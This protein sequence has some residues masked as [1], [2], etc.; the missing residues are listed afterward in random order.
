[1]LTLDYTIKRG[2]E[3]FK[4]YDRW[5]TI[6]SNIFMLTAPNGHGKS[7]FLNVI[8]L[9]LH[10]DKKLEN[11]RISESIKSKLVNTANRKDQELSFDINIV[12]SKGISLSLQKPKNKAIKVIEN[13]GAQEKTLTSDLF[14]KKYFLIYDIPENPLGKLSMLVS[15]VDSE[16]KRYN[17]K[18]SDLRIHLNDII[19]EVQ[20][21]KNPEDIEDFKKNIDEARL[22]KISLEGKLNKAKDKNDVLFNYRI[23]KAYESNSKA[24]EQIQSNLKKHEAE[25][26]QVNLQKKASSKHTSTLKESREKSEELDSLLNSVK[27]TMSDFFNSKY[28]AYPL[29]N[30]IVFSESLDT[31]TLPIGLDKALSMVSK[32]LQ[33]CINDPQ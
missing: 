24:L 14:E 31:Y 9:G 32:D 2:T 5:K 33:E 29:L 11:Q 21:K 17:K 13:D 3:E 15:E 16:Q 6:D 30:P 10:G 28:K 25:E 8:A 22:N 27:E 26:T 1:M 12:N 23:L 20:S 18:L 19:Q 4:P 7:T